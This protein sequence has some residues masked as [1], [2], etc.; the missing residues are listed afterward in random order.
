MR[1]RVLGAAAAGVA[2]VTLAG[3]TGGVYN[4]TLPGGPNLGSH[5]YTVT[6]QFTDVLDLVPQSS[7]KVDDVDV[8]EVRRIGLTDGG[9]LAVVT[10]QLNGDVQLPANAT[11]TISQT[12]LLGEKFIALARPADPHGSLH[13]GAVIPV[14]HT[15]QAV[16]FE[17]VFGA[18]SLLLNGGGV[19]QLHEIVLELNKAVGGDHSAAL[20]SLLH[21]ADAVVH[22]IDAR[23]GDIVAAL[24]QV[25]TLA[26][27]LNANSAEL[28]TALRDLPAGLRV[29]ARQRGQLVAM[30]NALGRLSRTT[31]HTVQAG[32]RAFV[33]DLRSLAPTLRRLTAAGQDLPT[34]LQ[35]LL[36]YPFPDSVLRAIRGDYLNAFITTNLN[37][38]GGSVVRLDTK[39]GRG[40]ATAPPAMLPPDDAVAPGLPQ[41][42]IVTTPSPKA[43][44]R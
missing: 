11:A 40:H 31:V 13:A 34:S 16:E 39:T 22:R 7:V 26:R 30:L 6:A 41:R 38:P 35:L 24:A 2:A 43:G 8:G 10:M 1:R 3:C 12:S 19:G 33:S 9:R 36:T 29:L 25:N 5:P 32:G 27:T 17:Q 42:T 4:V 18:L 15:Q 23:R 44:T 14:A 20:H 28:T 21:D 37:T